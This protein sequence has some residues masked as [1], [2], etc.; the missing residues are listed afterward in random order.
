MGVGDLHQSYARETSDAAPNYKYT[1]V[2]LVRIG[3]ISS[4]KR[5]SVIHR[6]II[7]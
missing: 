4:M 1:K 5:H 7:V 2:C 3:V 6:I